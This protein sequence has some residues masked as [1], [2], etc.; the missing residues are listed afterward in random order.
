MPD[1]LLTAADMHR[2]NSVRP[3]ALAG[4][5]DRFMPEVAVGAIGP[6]AGMAHMTKLSVGCL[7]L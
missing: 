7:S 2:E 4:G 6:V 1:T 5:R 3:A